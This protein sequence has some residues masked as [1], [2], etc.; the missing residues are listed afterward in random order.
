[1]DNFDDQ[2]YQTMQALNYSSTPPNQVYSGFSQMR[3]TH[4]A[5]PSNYASTKS[6]IHDIQQTYPENNKIHKI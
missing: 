5:D 2:T 6:L 1:M 3:T 4:I